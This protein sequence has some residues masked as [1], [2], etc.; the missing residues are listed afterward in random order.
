[1]K[2]FELR[3]ITPSAYQD[4][5]LP[6][7][8]KDIVFIVDKP[9]ILDFGCGFGQLL[10]ALKNEGLNSIDGLDMDTDAIEHCKKLGFNC[11]DAKDDDSFYSTHTNYYDF[12][13]AS[14]VIEHFS[15]DDI[16]PQLNKLKDLLKPDGA[17]IVMVPNAQ[18]NTG[19]YWAY[20]DF[21]HNLL[22]TSGSIY[23]VLRAA[24][25]SKIEFLDTD[26]TYGLPIWK[27]II[28]KGLLKFYKFNCFFWNR[29]TSSDYHESSPIIYSYE[30]K[31]MAKK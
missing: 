20:E 9:V 26:C 5:T 3:N 1:M 31:V 24:G 16:I 19:C 21:T 4:F 17:L 27:K 15:K 28:K 18:S 25:F 13:I 29:I 10:N 30:I 6:K 12:I 8:I 11:F 7:Y 23:F 2:Y 14:H 22:F